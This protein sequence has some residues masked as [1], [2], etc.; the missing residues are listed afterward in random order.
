MEILNSTFQILSLRTTEKITK[1]QVEN[2][3]L[4][5][6]RI[7]IFLTST[8][9]SAYGSFLPPRAIATKNQITAYCKKLTNRKIEPETKTQTPQGSAG[10]GRAMTGEEGSE[11]KPFF[12]EHPAKRQRLPQNILKNSLI[13]A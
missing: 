2:A 1:S 13:N 6:K 3:D 7:A 11:S 4:S 5:Q 10:M 9:K 12:N 8:R